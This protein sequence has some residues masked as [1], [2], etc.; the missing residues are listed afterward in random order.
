MYHPS[1]QL[2]LSDSAC[3]QKR[4]PLLWPL[5]LRV[6]AYQLG[7]L[8][9]RLLHLLTC[10]FDPFERVKDGVLALEPCHHVRR[11]HRS[12]A[13][14]PVSRLFAHVSVA[15]ASQ[16]PPCRRGSGPYPNYNSTAQARCES[17]SAANAANALTFVHKH[18]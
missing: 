14:I 18:V 2:A 17:A 10:C 7:Q 13:P 11:E 5:A 16:N 6:G 4:L 15:P 1:A 3:C 8:L 9:P 12:L